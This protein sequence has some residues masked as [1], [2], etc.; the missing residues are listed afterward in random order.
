MSAASPRIQVVLVSQEPDTVGLYLADR[1]YRVVVR[2]D[3][4]AALRTLHAAAYDVA[5]VDIDCPDGQ[6]FLSALRERDEALQVMVLSDQLV[7]GANSGRH[8]SGLGSVSDSGVD[9]VAKAMPLPELEHLIYK[10]SQ[11]T[12]LH[13]ENFRLRQLLRYSEAAVSRLEGQA[14]AGA[15]G[16]GA[17]ASHSPHYLP[18]VGGE[19]DLES[20]SRAHV[21]A[22]LE[23]HRGNKAQAARALG[24]NRRS[25]YRL[26]EKYVVA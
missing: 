20:L 5:V 18:V 9:Y 23:R 2:Q 1:G 12:K 24:I 25:L 19:A 26:L 10:S 22:V 8:G 6:E 7:S 13:R 15:Q 11:I 14:G 4:A 16:A 21:L 3:C 17:G